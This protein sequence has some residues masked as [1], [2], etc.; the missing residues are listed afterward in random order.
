MPGST[1]IAGV[2]VYVPLR[3]ITNEYV[4][5]RLVAESSGYLNRE[6]LARIIEKAEGKM[7]KAG[8]SVRYWCEPDEYGTDIA[9]KAARLALSDAGLEA[10]DIDYILYTGM[11]KAFVEPATA[12]VLRHEL[13]AVRAN[14]I[15]TQDACA[16][17]VKSVQ[18]GDSLIRN[19]IC[20]RILIVCGERTFDWADF[21][22]KTIDE[23]SWKF[24]SLTIGDAAGA[25][26]LEATDEPLYTRD[27]YHFDYSHVIKSGTYAYCHI[28]LNHRLGTRYKLHSHSGALFKTV[29]EAGWELVTGRMQADENWVRQRLDQV[30][31]H[32]IGN[33]I[34]EF[35]F[36]T[37]RPLFPEAP[38][39]Y[40][41]YF[42]GYGNVASASFPLSLHLARENGSLQR[43]HR[44][45][46]VCPAAGAQIGI[47]TFVY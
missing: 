8:C 18:I 35:I 4:L 19:G 34:A 30:F 11:S 43:G 5:N 14:V 26:V 29:T 28:G 41:S 22:C 27:G 13:G 36:P 25:V 46:F 7:A 42:A 40:L 24:G 39:R 33:Y 37:F 45:M 47:M 15:D 6:D 17:F 10:P 23:L 21:C 16:S 1:K 20:R 3:K 2:G 31:F 44:V 12:H 32:D 38:H 9:L